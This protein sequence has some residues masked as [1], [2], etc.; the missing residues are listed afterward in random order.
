MLDAVDFALRYP[1][2]P[3][4]Q[5]F[6][7]LK[8]STRWYVTTSCKNDT[9][10]RETRTCAYSFECTRTCIHAHSSATRPYKFLMCLRQFLCVFVLQNDLE[11]R[12]MLTS[13]VSPHE[14]KY[15]CRNEPIVGNVSA[16]IANTST[17]ASPFVNATQTNMHTRF[18]ERQ[19]ACN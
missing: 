17:N 6:M 4:K 11:V 18:F 10:M 9:H 13:T 8:L 16:G 3:S 12:E 1:T 5:E 15:K 7:L 14:P 19:Q 2:S